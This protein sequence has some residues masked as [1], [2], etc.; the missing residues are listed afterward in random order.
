MSMVFSV[1]DACHKTGNAQSYN[2]EKNAYVHEPHP[3]QME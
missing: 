1:L 3:F 2:S